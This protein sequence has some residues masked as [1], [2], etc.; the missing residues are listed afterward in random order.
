MKII[1][2]VSLTSTLILLVVVALLTLN[3]SQNVNKLFKQNEKQQIE[4]VTAGVENEMKSQF[5]LLT[6]GLEP[7][8]QNQ[9]ILEA[10]AARDR[11][12][13]AQL[14]LPLMDKLKEQGVLQFQFHL[15]DATS[16][17]RVHE[18]EKYGDDLSSFRQTVVEAN[19]KHTVV[20]GLEGGVSGAGFRY[21]VP[22][23]YKGNYIGS[24]ELG[25]GLANDFLNKFKDDY[26]GEWTLYGVENSETA[27]LAS[28]TKE[29]ESN[30]TNNQLKKLQQNKNVSFIKNDKFILAIPLA[31]YSGSMNWYMEREIDY[32]AFLKQENSQRTT[33]ILVG[34]ISSIIGLLILIYIMRRILKPL[35]T[36]TSKMEQVSTGDLTLEKINV[37]SK[38][39]IGILADCFNTMTDSLKSLILNM[40]DKSMELTSNAHSITHSIQDSEESTNNIVHAIKNINSDSQNTMTS[41]EESTKAMEE[42]TIGIVRVA[43]NSSTIAQAANAM[44]ELAMNGNEAILSAVN[45]MDTIEQHTNTITNIVT[46]LNENSN[47]IGT[48]MQLITGIAE[49]TNL[50]ALNAAIE[51]ARAGEAG[52][53]FAVVADEIRKLADQTSHSASQVH[54]LISDIQSKSNDAM[55]SMDSSRNEVNEGAQAIHHVGDIFKDIKSAINNITEQIDD[56]SALAEEMSAGSEEV[57]AS[58]Q[59]ITFMTNNAVENANHASEAVE[60]QLAITTELANA[61]KNLSEMSKALEESVHQFKI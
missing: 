22:L 14:T 28:T 3:A 61:S 40:R 6:I 60:H 11:G 39:E 49:Q 44:N 53:G 48:I 56:L 10:F 31:D 50:L 35:S 32:T 42:M 25:M 5:D 2:K 41:T 21:V 1:T 29:K 16:F 34:L 18:P 43:D 24:V 8:I 23:E 20:K 37:S 57:T 30:I 19:N 13:L 17:Y 33:L 46:N 55:Q 47:E 51:A 36:I 7:I 26:D 59:E 52:K 9:Q 27:W 4:T 45:Q 58:V 38:D 12:K 15:P 54:E